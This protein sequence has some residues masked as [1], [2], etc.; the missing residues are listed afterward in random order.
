LK[1]WKIK[2][3]EVEVLDETKVEVEVFLRVVGEG[4][5]EDKKTGSFIPL[6]AAG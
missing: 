6:V 1:E 2:A 4:R 5:F 3:V